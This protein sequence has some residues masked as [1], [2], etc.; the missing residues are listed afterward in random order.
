M[1]FFESELGTLVP[2]ENSAS[3][4]FFPSRLLPFAHQS[5]LL[6]VCML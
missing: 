1:W 4:S 2:G 5:Q 6:G 3:I